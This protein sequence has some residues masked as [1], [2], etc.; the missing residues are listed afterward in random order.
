MNFDH[1]VECWHLLE[2]WLQ[3]KFPRWIM[4]PGQNSTWNCDPNPRSQFNLGSQFNVKSRPG[5]TI[6]RGSM[7]L[8]TIQREILI[9]VTIQG[10]IMTRGH[11]STLSYDP[12][13]QFNLELWP[14][15]KTSHWSVTRGIVPHWIVIQFPGLRSQF[16]VH[17]RPGVKIQ[18][19]IKTQG[20]NS[21]VVQILSVG[22]VVIQWPPVSGVAI[23]HKKSLVS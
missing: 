7:T 4:K 9:L 11:N 22:G 2:L 20:H 14:R 12:G 18:R 21:I 17:L 8:V 3:G 6:Q 13:S 1:A 15:V 19:G 16:N 10:R 23:P 5:V